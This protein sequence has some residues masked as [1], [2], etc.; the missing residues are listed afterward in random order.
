MAD[1][2]TRQ[3][4]GMFIN[5][6]ASVQFQDVTRQLIEQVGWQTRG[7]SRSRIVFVRFASEEPHER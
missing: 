2:S 7:Q 4:A 3:L 6:L 5:A 1:S